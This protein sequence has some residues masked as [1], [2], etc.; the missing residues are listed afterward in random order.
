M[1]FT[2][3]EI[4]S[5]IGEGG[6]ATVYLAVNNQTSEQVAIKV[7][8]KEFCYN[9]NIRSRFIDE[10]RKM[11]RLNN[12]NIVNF[13]ELIEDGDDVAIV[14]EYVSGITLRELLT[15]KKLSND[16][17]KNYLGQIVFALDY[18]H[19][20]GFIHRD[21]K[22]SNFIIDDAGKLKLT[23]FGISKDTTGKLD[24]H[25]QTS[26]SASMGTP[27]YMSPEQ[28]RSTKDITYLS[29]IYS[30][31]V[32]LWEMASGKKPYNTETLSTFDLQLKIVQEKLPL[33]DTMWDGLIQKA[34]EKKEEERLQKLDDF[35]TVENEDKTVIQDDRTII[36]ESP[37]VKKDL[38]PFKN[39]KENKQNKIRLVHRA[40]LKRKKRLRLV[41]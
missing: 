29:D 31:G 3:Y 38:K 20:L 37:I 16:E 2:K 24:E 17:I 10:S 32:I 5:L 30:L 11:V 7:L 1:N 22:P 34:T 21:I 40:G 36:V 12:P 18:F 25:T 19:Q 15:Q 4:K 6:M 13:I 8:N 27:M 41:F 39:K 9:K 33:T 26:T 23:D 35:L 28:I 14:M